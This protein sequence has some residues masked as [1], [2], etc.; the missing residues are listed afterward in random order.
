M[1]GLTKV[2][3]TFIHYTEAVKFTIAWVQYVCTL[4]MT[5]FSVDVF[6]QRENYKETSDSQKSLWHL[7]VIFTQRGVLMKLKSC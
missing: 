4:C 6:N 5:V 2:K 3:A 1:S 7:E